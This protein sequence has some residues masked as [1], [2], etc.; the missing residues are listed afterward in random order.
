[1]KVF[2]SWSGSTSGQIA[3]FLREWLPN[4]LQNVEPFLS[5]E[6]IDKGARWLSAVTDELQV[7]N[8]GLICLTPENLT[9]PWILFEAGSLS[10][11]IG[12]SRVV[13]ILFKLEPSDVQGP[14][15][16]FQMVNFGQEEMYRLLQSINNAGG[17]RKLDEN[18]LQKIF[19]KF[20]PELDANIATV[21]FIPH[22]ERHTIPT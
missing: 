7:C 1:M 4:V 16:Q 9:A 14:L 2:I 21:Q 22:E 18:R 5:N 15:T 3:R 13:P 17:E 12:R 19:V 8:F 11:I 20:W 10:K 6:D